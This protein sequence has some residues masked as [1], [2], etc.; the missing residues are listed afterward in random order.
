MVLDDRDRALLASLRKDARRPLVALARDIGLSRSATQERLAR[1]LR[2]G[3]IGGF[4]TV[5]PHP[6]AQLCAHL[7]LK[8][9]PGHGCAALL[10]HLRQRPEITAIH[11][12]AGETDMVLRVEAPGV[13]AIEETRAAISALPGVAVVTT[14]IV[15]ERYL[16]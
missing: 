6:E 13:A 2:T 7:L 15:L 3:V 14:L 4:T 5:E 12:V 16:G 11:A 1:L 10:P 8:H 9:Q